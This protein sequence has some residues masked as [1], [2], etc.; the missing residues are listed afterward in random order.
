MNTKALIST[1]RLQIKGHIAKMQR[2]HTDPVTKV[3][4]GKVLELIQRLEATHKE[5][6]APE[7]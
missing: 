3:T 1:G 4:D 7:T 2:A 5:L 6:V